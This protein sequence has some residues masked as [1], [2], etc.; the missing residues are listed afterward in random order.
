MLEDTER[1]DAVSGVD[2]GRTIPLLTDE[3]GTGTWSMRSGL[4]AREAN[5]S[6]LWAAKSERFNPRRRELSFR[7]NFAKALLTARRVFV[8]PITVIIRP[9]E[10]TVKAVALAPAGI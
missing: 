6:S 4:R 3:R 10:S 8:S 2:W 9:S 5:R 7:S 1:V